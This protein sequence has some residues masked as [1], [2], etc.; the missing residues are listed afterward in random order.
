MM[1]VGSRGGYYSEKSPKLLLYEWCQRQKRPRPK[2]K[3]VP[4]QQ[5]AEGQPDGPLQYRWEGGGG[6]G[7]DG[8]QWAWGVE[9]RHMGW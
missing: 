5:Q 2:F 9:V 4:Q 7:E 1:D 6:R 3:V 8:A